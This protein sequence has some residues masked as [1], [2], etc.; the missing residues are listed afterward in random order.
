MARAR[1][2]QANVL[3]Q[4]LVHFGAVGVFSE[5]EKRPATVSDCQPKGYKHARQDSNLRPTD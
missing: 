4:N 1:K 5:K 2:V 3:R